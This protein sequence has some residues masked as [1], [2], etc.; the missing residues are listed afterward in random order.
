MEEVLA[1]DTRIEQKPGSNQDSVGGKGGN[2]IADIIDVEKV[3]NEVETMELDKKDT[4]NDSANNDGDNYDVKFIGEL[5][6]V[7]LGFY[8]VSMVF[9]LFNS[10]T[11]QMNVFWTNFFN[12]C[13]TSP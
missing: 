2:A 11:S 6:F 3:T 1:G 13:L 10:D 8:V 9:Q 7:C 12:Q 5:K 4:S